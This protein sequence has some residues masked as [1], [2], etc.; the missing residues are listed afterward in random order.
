MCVYVWGG[1]TVCTTVWNNGGGER[2]VGMKFIVFKRCVKG[3][4]VVR[5]RTSA[6]RVKTDQ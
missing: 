1:G 2:L 3:S 5:V 6:W 4:G